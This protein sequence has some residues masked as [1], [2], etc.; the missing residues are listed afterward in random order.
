MISITRFLIVRNA[1][2]LFMA[3]MVPGSSSTDVE[4]LFCITLILIVMLT[5][6]LTIV[7]LPVNTVVVL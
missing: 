1:L 6:I 7:F 2:F 4:Q 5:P 3:R